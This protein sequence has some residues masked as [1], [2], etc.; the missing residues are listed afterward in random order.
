M[1]LTIAICTFNRAHLLRATLHQLVRTALP[2]NCSLEV[3]VVDNGSTDHTT[4]VLNEFSDL[5]PLRVAVEPRSGLSHARNHAI[6]VASGEYILWADDDVLVDSEWLLEYE[7]AFRRH[8]DAAFFGGP[9]TP[10]FEP[11]PPKWLVDALPDIGGVYAARALGDKPFQFSAAT[12]PFGANFAI[13]SDVQRRY[14]YDPAFGQQHGRIMVGEETN[15]L[16]AILASGETGWWVPNA[17]VHHFIPRQRQR[18]R[19]LAKYW[20]AVGRHAAASIPPASGPALF[21]KPKWLWRAAIQAELRYR[22]RR[23]FE[24]PRTTLDDLAAARIAWGKLLAFSQRNV[25]MLERL[26]C[27]NSRQIDGAQARFK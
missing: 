13:K 8:A 9:I 7:S 21:G 3:V 10:I 5:L 15:V 23:L 26:V 4:A 14:L 11:V 2:A 18:R 6:A 27:S 25:G 24:S 17:K 19:H 22:I 1:R 20:Y 16:R 12:L